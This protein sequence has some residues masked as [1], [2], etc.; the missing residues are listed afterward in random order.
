MRVLL[1]VLFEIMTDT[2]HIHIVST[3]L[4]GKCQAL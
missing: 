1:F 2:T 3:K 4:E